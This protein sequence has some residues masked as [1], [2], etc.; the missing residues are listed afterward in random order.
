MNTL[1]K[2]ITKGMK[3]QRTKKNVVAYRRSCEVNGTGLSHYI[4]MDR[5]NK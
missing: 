5:K 1:K 4:L 2:K 3:N